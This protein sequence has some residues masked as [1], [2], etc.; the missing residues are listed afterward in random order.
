[1]EDRAGCPAWRTQTLNWPLLTPHSLLQPGVQQG[2]YLRHPFMAGAEEQ[3]DFT[4]GTFS[5]KV[6][7]VISSRK[8]EDL[9]LHSRKQ[10]Q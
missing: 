2:P 7:L 1:M 6:I 8:P 9:R 4:P 10:N 3:S 5:S